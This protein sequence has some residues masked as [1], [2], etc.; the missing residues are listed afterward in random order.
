M[1]ELERFGI[2]RI[3]SNKIGRHEWFIAFPKKL[4]NLLRLMEA[5]KILI[6]RF[7]E[8]KIQTLELKK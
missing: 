3:L 4:E 5:E 6:T 1:K 8:I 7:G 2:K